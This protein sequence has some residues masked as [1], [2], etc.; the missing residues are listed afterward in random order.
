VGGLIKML[1]DRRTAIREELKLVERLLELHERQVGADMVRS[2]EGTNEVRL[3]QRAEESSRL[4]SRKQVE[5][6]KQAK[7]Y[8]RIDVRPPPFMRT[9]NGMN[10]I[11]D[12]AAAFLRR[13]GSRAESTEIHAALILQGLLKEGPSE[14]SKVTSYLGRAKQKFDNVRG[15]GYGLTEW[16]TVAQS[17]R[18][19]TLD[20]V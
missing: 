11:L 16:R 6:V 8:D 2:L 14:R 19:T 7:G 1:I 3:N 4:A 20:L 18:Q 10:A 17:V 5:L 12:A 9:A 15:K 13:K